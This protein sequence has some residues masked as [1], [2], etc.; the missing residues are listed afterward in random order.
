MKLFNFFSKES[1][2]KKK[3][4]QKLYAKLDG[5]IL[6]FHKA[7]EHYKQTLKD[8]DIIGVYHLHRSEDA[9]IVLSPSSHEH[10]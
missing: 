10:S 2:R 4:P 5:G 7:D 9:H 8:G 6:S 1:F 3:L